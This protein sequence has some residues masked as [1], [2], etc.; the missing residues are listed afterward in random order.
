MKCPDCEKEMKRGIVRVGSGP[1]DF[2]AGDLLLKGVVNETLFSHQLYFEHGGNKTV[3]I[4]PN[5]KR[6]AFGC[7]SC[8]GVF[9]TNENQCVIDPVTGVVTE[10]DD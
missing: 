7:P 5:E 8:L 2:V 9:I 4:M 6:V 1:D 10:Y 3:F